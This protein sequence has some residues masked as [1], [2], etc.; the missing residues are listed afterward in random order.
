MSCGSEVAEPDSA[1]EDVVGAEIE[2]VGAE[3]VVAAA[4]PQPHGSVPQPTKLASAV[5]IV[6]V[7]APVD[8]HSA[9]AEAETEES[10]AVAVGKVWAAEIAVAVETGSTADIVHHVSAVEQELQLEVSKHLPIQVPA[11]LLLSA[12]V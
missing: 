12:E 8:A 9:V 5:A 10:I 7:Q 1:A 6:E 2:F 3:I 11:V 4:S